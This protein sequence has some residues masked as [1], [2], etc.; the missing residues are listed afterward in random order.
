MHAG[1]EPHINSDDDLTVI[2]CGCGHR[3]KELS[4]A[5]IREK[6]IPW[7]CDRCGERNPY[8][9]K[10]HPSERAKA[11]FILARQVR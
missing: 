3:T 7:Y 9:I 8:W 4:R 2:Y 1:P 6:G 5:E 11:E 10:F